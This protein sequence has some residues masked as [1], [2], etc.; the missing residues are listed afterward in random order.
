MRSDQNARGVQTMLK[1]M[2]DSKRSRHSISSQA[3]S[4]CGGAQLVHE[5]LLRDVHDVHSCSA[6]EQSDS[7]FYLQIVLKDMVDSKR[8]GLNIHHITVQGNV[9]N[10]QIREKHL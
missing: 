6:R 4:P 1:D 9:L 7:H 8:M 5:R 3:M 2:A 10:N